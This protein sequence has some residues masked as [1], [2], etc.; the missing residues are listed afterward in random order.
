M[1]TT[2]TVSLMIGSMAPRLQASESLPDSVLT[3]DLT[4]AQARGLLLR[5]LLLPGWGEHRLQYHSRGYLLNGSEALFWLAYAALHYYAVTQDENMR[6][7]G[8]LHAGIQA[9]GKDHVFFTNIGN[10]ASLYEFNDQKLRYRQ[11]QAVYPDTPEYFWAWDS[12]A[13]RHHFDRL[14]LRS[15]IARRNASFMIT[16]LVV[17]RIV[18]MFDIVLLTRQRVQPLPADIDAVVAPRPDGL[19]LSVWYRF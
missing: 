4:I 14:R 16:G 3:R 12:D 1:L 10:Y 17:N 8:T 2:L 9:Q 13:A 5:S 7:Y 11:F 19:T 6:T 15:A 18:S